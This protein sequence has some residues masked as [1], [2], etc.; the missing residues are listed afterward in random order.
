M[1]KNLFLITPMLIAI[2]ASLPLFAQENPNSAV[3]KSENLYN[4]APFTECHASTI[5]E[6]ADGLAVAF[7]AG[8]AEKNPDVGIW[9]C[10]QND[11][12]W[13]EPVEIANGISPDG[14]RY[15][16]W[17]PVLY[18]AGNGKLLLFY[19]VGPDPVT[20]WGMMMKSADN[21][22]TWSEPSRLPEGILGPVKNKAVKLANG[23][24]LCPVS[25]EEGEWRVYFE[26]TSDLGK[27]WSR[28]DFVKDPANMRAI[29]PAILVH[30]NSHLQALCRTRKNV[31]GVTLSMDGG[32]TWTPLK[33]TSLPNPNSGID[34]VTLH[35]GRHLLVYNP[36]IVPEG[37]WT[38]DRSPISMAIS[39]NGKKW[40]KIADLDTEPGELSY[41]A[42]IQSGDGLVHITYTWKRNTVRH[43][44]IDPAFIR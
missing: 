36:T 24:L 42:I 39:K 32:A 22:H 41:P 23:D 7:F 33:A 12:E 17:N 3:I 9:L 29:Q 30:N 37:R 15:P 19:K 11:G 34:A 8:T 35:D 6:T 40:R 26:R 25:T 2:V 16:C 38:G 44:I 43:L 18:Y 27:T 4:S 31:V 13:A 14:K 28:T 1:R 20:W 10:L 5:A 21:G